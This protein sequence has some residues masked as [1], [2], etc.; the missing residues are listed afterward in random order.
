M[1][2]EVSPY[3]TSS[4]LC[5]REKT[6]GM[7]GGWPLPETNLIFFL[8]CSMVEIYCQKYFE[9]AGF[10]RNSKVFRQIIFLY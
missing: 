1:A 6:A 9:I 8:T 4:L 7:V 2:S 10:G 3:S 5:P